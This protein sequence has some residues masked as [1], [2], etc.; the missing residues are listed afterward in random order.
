MQFSHLLNLFRALSIQPS[1]LITAAIVALFSPLRGEDAELALANPSLTTLS[2]TRVIAFDNRSTVTLEMDPRNPAQ[3]I[4][5]Q[6]GAEMLRTIPGFNLIRKGGTDGDPTFRGMAGSRLGI[7][8][9]G[10]LVLGGCGNRMD[11]PTAYVFPSAYDRVT[12]VRGPQSVRFGAG[13]SAGTVLFERDAQR[14]E[15]PTAEWL[16]QLTFGSFGRNDQLIDT[17]VGNAQVDAR[18][19]A[20]RS[21]ADDYKD[22]SGQ[23]AHTQYERWSLHGT[24][25]WNVNAAHRLELGGI[26]SDG[27]AAYADRGMDGTLFERQN[28]SLRWQWTNTHSGPLRSAEAQVYYNYIDHVMDNFRLR[29]FTPTMMMPNPMASNPDRETIGGRIE[30]RWQWT[31]VLTTQTGIDWQRNT[32]TT[33]SSMNAA[34]TSVE[35]LPRITDA[36]FRSIGLFSENTLETTDQQR[37]VSGIRVDFHRANDERLTVPVGMMMPPQPNPTANQRRSETLPSGFL[38]WEYEPSQVWLFSIGLGHSQRFPDYWELINKESAGSLSAFDTRPEKTTQIDLGMTRRGEQ[39]EYSLNLFANRIDDYIL[40]ESQVPKGMRMATI[41]RNIDAQSYGGELA[42]QYALDENWRLNGSLAY[43]RGRN[44]TDGQ[45]LAQQPPLEARLGLTYQQEKWSLG[46]LLRLVDSQH[47]FAM[48]QGNIV[49]QDLGRSSGF[50][51]FSLHGNLQLSERNRL[52]AGVDNLFDKTYA[53]H[54]SRGGSSVAG[55]PPPTTRANEPGR[56]IWV[57]WQFSY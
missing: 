45:P 4:P 25:G 17:T 21:A 50:A 52:S 44:R 34:V 33:R 27:E 57:Q 36:R 15:A 48:N 19:S 42:A 7:L 10:E 23:A 56:N 9:D 35:S 6:D 11:P 31:E 16:S 5:A 43:V 30:S 18:F 2:T 55:F 24:L 40:I 49:G 8:L 20:T 51:V 14:F 29:T 13:N 54:L 37:W 47:R 22:G 26:L 32:H 12:F 3:P 46:S 53:E 1:L 28:L 38:R 41:S 39:L